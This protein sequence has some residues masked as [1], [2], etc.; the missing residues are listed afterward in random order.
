MF[1][2]EGNVNVL[3]ITGSE[4]RDNEVGAGR[5]RG[6]GGV[7]SHAQTFIVNSFFQGNIEMVAD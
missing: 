1:V 3:Q 5:G 2:E 6:A 7:E 4:I